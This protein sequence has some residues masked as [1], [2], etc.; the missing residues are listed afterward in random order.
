MKRI[1]FSYIFFYLYKIY[2]NYIVYPLKIYN[3]YNNIEDLLSFDSTYTTLE[4]GTP[5]QKVNFF[6]SLNHT[7]INLTDMGCKYTNL[8]NKN[9]SETF[10]IIYELEKEY[11]TN[12]T[13]YLVTESI[14]FNNNMNLLKLL[15]INDYPF[16]YSSD[17]TNNKTKL[18]GNIGLSIIPFELYIQESYQIK[19]YTDYIK[20]YGADQKDDFSFFHY[21]G[22][23]YLVYGIFLH[24][25]FK[26]IFKDVNS[27]AWVHPIIKGYRYTSGWEISMK[28]CY[29]NNI[30]NKNNII[31]EINPLFEF[32]IGTN[33]YNIN[34]RNDFFN[35]YL[36]KKICSINKNYKFILY[37]CNADK[38]GNEDINKFPTLFMS[39]TD[40]QHVFEMKGEDLF[41]NLNNKYYFKIVFPIKYDN[42][43]K[44]IIGKIFLRKY[45]V[46]FSPSN[47]LIGFY[48]KPNM[49]KTV[50]T[51][52]KTKNI[53][54]EEIIEPIFN[55]DSYNNNKDNNNYFSKELIG[56]I[57][58]IIIA[59]L[60]T[61]LGLLIGKKIFFKRRKR[62]NELN[63]DYY[64]YDIN[65][66]KNNENKTDN[67]KDNNSFTSIEMY[68]KLGVK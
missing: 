37:E 5:P 8:Y 11:Q 41:F 44:W 15:K 12:N 23:D 45:T 2:N 43:N 63:D 38:F 25:E 65:T 19:Y 42:T 46:V 16:Y 52:N 66:N 56:Y 35:S 29:Y 57:K 27:I 36:N 22:Q 3:E 6:F 51:V 60:F 58:I 21:K 34:I 30:H 28:E 55:H 40:I 64:Q 53:E 54:K 61:G 9:Y 10:K 14:Y 49:G 24:L 18:C 67:N 13:K 47:R 1:C 48:I 20:S 68:S 17:I 50:K 33:T 59:L 26:D 39:N 32:I 31:F 7:K 62:A 4:M